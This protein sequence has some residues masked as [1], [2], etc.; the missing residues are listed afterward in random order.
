MSA[1]HAAQLKLGRR[2]RYQLAECSSACSARRSLSCRNL[3]GGAVQASWRERLR[4]CP[5]AA[6]QPAQNPVRREALPCLPMP[7][8]E[9]GGRR[10]RARWRWMPPW[11]CPAE[12]T[13]QPRL[14]GLAVSGLGTGP[15]PMPA[16]SARNRLHRAGRR[17][18]AGPR[19]DCG[20]RPA[21]FTARWALTWVGMGAGPAKPTRNR[22]RPARTI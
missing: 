7:C 9:V 20:G 4:G 15:G 6:H 13:V 19:R 14:T 21:R 17:Q 10:S 5:H 22:T 18:L 2:M 16:A 3:R 8:P 11:N 1:L 12:L